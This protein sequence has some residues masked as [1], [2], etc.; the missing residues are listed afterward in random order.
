[1]PYWMISFFGAFWRDLCYACK[2]SKTEH[3]S[4]LHEQT[5]CSHM[6]KTTNSKFKTITHSTKWKNDDTCATICLARKHDGS[7]SSIYSSCRSSYFFN[8]LYAFIKPQAIVSFCTFGCLLSFCPSHMSLRTCAMPYWMISFFGAFWRDRCYACKVSKTEHQSQLHEQTHC[9]HMNKTTN[10]KF[11][12]ITH[13]TKWKNDDTCATIC[14]ARKHKGS[15]SSIYSS[16]RSSYF[17][18]LL[19]A[20]IKPQAIVSFCTFGCL[21]SFCPSHMSLRTC[22]MPYWMISFFGAFWRD[23]CYACKVSKTEHQLWNRVSRSVVDD[24][25]GLQYVE[26]KAPIDCCVSLAKFPSSNRKQQQPQQCA[27][28]VNIRTRWESERPY[29]GDFDFWV[30]SLK[31][32]FNLVR[33]PG[34]QNEDL[35]GSASHISIWYITYMIVFGLNLCCTQFT[36]S[37]QLS[38]RWAFK[39]A[40]ARDLPTCKVQVVEV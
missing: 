1:M 36:L 14:L 21:L 38:T 24:L 19:Y 25:V 31:S 23:R 11:K 12:T 34:Q 26:I 5:H 22:A 32:F 37:E 9:S 2:V 20:F 15:T 30:C 35:K 17:F 27:F 7:T 3:Q 33:S 6:N 39:S 29:F 28:S 4:Q 8:L 18:N 16:C 13:S 40:S 10:S